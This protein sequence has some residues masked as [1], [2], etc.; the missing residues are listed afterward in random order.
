MT[1]WKTIQKAGPNVIA[2][3]I[4]IGKIVY[5]PEKAEKLYVF[6]CSVQLG[7]II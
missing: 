1:S 3:F 6:I 4:Q 2:A 7:N 5:P